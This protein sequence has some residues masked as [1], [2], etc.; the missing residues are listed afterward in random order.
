M[1]Q[2]SDSF[3]AGKLLIAMPGMQDP[4]FERSVIFMCA[5]SAQGAM[6][7]IVNKPV[8]GLDFC[9]L[10][11]RYHLNGGP[12]TPKV[13]ILFGGPVEIN[14]GFF[15]HSTDYADADN[16]HPVTTEISLTASVG[17]LKAISEG[18]GPRKR[19]LAL[20]Y[21]GWDEG[22]IESEIRDNGWIHCDADI[23]LIFTPHY[24]TVWQKAIAKLGVDLSGLTGSSGR[25]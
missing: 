8:E 4:R 11:Q 1:E 17:I 16:T 2:S 20:G 14:R 22:Q 10:L 25:A 6:G 3:L 13:P 24:E 19:L 5:H 18:H 15:L 23:D 7:L 9:E 21:A 12:E